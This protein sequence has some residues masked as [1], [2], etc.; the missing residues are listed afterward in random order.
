M[1]E[2]ER[3]KGISRYILLHRAWFIVVTIRFTVV[4]FV[5]IVSLPPYTEQHGT[6][7]SKNRLNM[8]FGCRTN[9]RHLRSRLFLQYFLN[10]T[11]HNAF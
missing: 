4:V 11:R 5:R 3:G 8:S 9:R 6:T 1:K 7:R 10:S 2:S